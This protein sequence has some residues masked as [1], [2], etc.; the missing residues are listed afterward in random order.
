VDGQKSNPD[1]QGLLMI[2]G[3]FKK[4]DSLQISSGQLR[5]P[6]K[7]KPCAF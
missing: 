6:V 2:T 4:A 3:D 7:I 5:Q 1:Y